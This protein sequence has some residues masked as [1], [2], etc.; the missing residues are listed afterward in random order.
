MHSTTSTARP[1]PAPDSECWTDNPE[2]RFIHDTRHFPDMVAYLDKQV[3]KFV[4]K[5]QADGLWDNTIL[6]FVGDNGTMEQVVSKMSDGREIK[7]GKGNATSNGTHVP[8]LIAWGDKIKSGRVSERLVDMTDFMPTMADAM[9]IEVPEEWRIDGI[10]LYPEL[11]GLEPLQRE[12]T[13]VHF[14]PLW[15]HKPYPR[16]AR[17]AFNT[18]YKYYWD[19]R[20]YHFSEDPM[21]QHPLD[22]TECSPEVQEL[23]AKLKAKVDEM[24]DWYPDKP[25]APRHGD[26]KSFYDANPQQAK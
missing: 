17:C 9:G 21:E 26:Y 1:Q 18:E 13:L 2:T 12:F 3:G 11:C 15:P 22:V 19:G 10:S 5:L 14:N 23:Y 16:A 4:D 7:G 24:P 25:G 20:F 8:L 6:I